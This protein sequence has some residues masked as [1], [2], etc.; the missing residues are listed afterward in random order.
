MLMMKVAIVTRSNV[1]TMRAKKV[2][3]LKMETALPINMR[4]FNGNK[5]VGVNKEII[6]V[7]RVSINLNKEI[8]MHLSH[9]I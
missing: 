2:T 5:T 7:L 4:V 8:K 9:G 1:M 3:G 6:P